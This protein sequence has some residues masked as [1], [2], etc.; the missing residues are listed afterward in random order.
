MTGL[1]KQYAL[2]TERQGRT[3]L[4]GNEPVDVH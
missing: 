3:V 1:L 4:A 2:G